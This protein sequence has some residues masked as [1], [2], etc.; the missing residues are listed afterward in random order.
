MRD[1]K[2]R[3]LALL[4]IYVKAVP[5]S[6]LLPETLPPLLKTLAASGRPG[7]SAPVA[8]RVAGLLRLLGRCG[9]FP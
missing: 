9:D 2:L 7:G 8:E 5:T 4:E 3:S 6:L 1:F